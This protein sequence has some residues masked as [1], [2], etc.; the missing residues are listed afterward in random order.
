MKELP[1][2]EQ[3]HADTGFVSSGA[4]PIDTP[5]EC[6]VCGGEELEMDMV[7]DGIAHPN[8]EM[9]GRFGAWH[10]QHQPEGGVDT[11]YC[12]PCEKQQPVKVKPEYGTMAQYWWEMYKWEV[13]KLSRTGPWVVLNEVSS[14]SVPYPKWRGGKSG[15]YNHGGA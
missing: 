7:L 8:A 12:V 4:L 9:V 6:S 1:I 13:A 10:P 5:Y 15:R 14:A 3:F 11:T 2:C